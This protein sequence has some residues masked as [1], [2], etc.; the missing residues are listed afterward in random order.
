MLGDQGL[1]HHETARAGVWDRGE[2]YS[3]YPRA[4]RDARQTECSLIK[5]PE[6]K[7]GV[8]RT[9]PNLDIAQ[10]QGRRQNNIILNGN[11]AKTGDSPSERGTSR[12]TLMHTLERSLTQLHA[13]CVDAYYTHS[14]D[15]DNPIE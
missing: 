5:Y 3:F 8:Y 10:F 1:G 2:D 14:P 4:D 12:L 9:K 13:D 11:K 15:N 6:S 7:N